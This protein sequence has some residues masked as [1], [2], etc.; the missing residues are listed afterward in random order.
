MGGNYTLG[1]VKNH[2]DSATS[3][4]A[5]SLN[6]DAEWG[7]SLQDV[8]HR[9]N[10]NFNVPFVYGMRASVNGNAQSAAPYNI[11][12]GRDDNQDGV[13]NDRPAGVGRNAARGAARFDMS[14]RLSRQ[15][16]FGPSRTT[17]GDRRPP[18]RVEGGPAGGAPAGGAAPQQQGR[19]VRVGRRP[20]RRWPGAGGGNPFEGGNGRFS[21]EVWIQANNVLNRVNY[22]NFVGNIQ[23]PFFGMRHVGG[24][25]EADRGRTELPVLTVFSLRSSVSSPAKDTELHSRSTSLMPGAGGP[26]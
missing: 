24:A 14:L 23:S 17:P 10:C 19:A 20:R 1:Q 12:T 6:P 4:P 16:T 11:T 5:N 9:V 13:V 2:A 3:L 8:R 26:A 22:L 25:A 15:I 21:A 7:P 18:G